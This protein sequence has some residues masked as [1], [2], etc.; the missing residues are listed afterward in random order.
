[1]K[2]KQSKINQAKLLVVVLSLD[3]L[4]S[5]ISTSEETK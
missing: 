3:K 5:R 1:M 4:D 2:I